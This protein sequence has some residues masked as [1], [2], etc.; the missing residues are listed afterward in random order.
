MTDPSPWL[1]CPPYGMAEHVVARMERIAHEVA[2]EWGLPLGPRIAAGRYS[3]V[4]PAGD[5]AILKIVPPE[6]DQAD[7]IAEALRFWDG[8]GA[9][10]LLRHDPAR[11]ALL[12]ERLVPGTEASQ[13]DEDEATAVA[14]AVGKKIWR[15]P[16]AGHTFR[17]TRDWVGRWLPA[18]DAHPLVPVARR[19]YEAMRP[20]SALLI[21]ADFHHHNLLRR[22]DDWVAID[23]K[24]IVGDPEF[25]VPAFLW[26]P[27]GTTPT[28]ARTERR[29]RAFADAGLDG[30]RI[31]QWAIVRGVCDGLPIG[32]GRSEADRPQLRVARQLL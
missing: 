29:I 25:D 16:A 8:T 6:D 4:A 2:A 18:G 5:R 12:L 22:G 10:R 31:R 23:P 14:I 32:P 9:V 27:L 3:Y 26:N 30:E 1:D 28:R 15:A 7:H 24:P 20:A 19:T 11:R 13:L 17:S 21:H